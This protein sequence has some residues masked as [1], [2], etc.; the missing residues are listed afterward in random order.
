MGSA[1]PL[2]GAKAPSPT[3]AALGQV[4]H[5]IDDLPV[6]A[7]LEVEVGAEAEAGA[8]ADP[9]HLALAHLLADGDRYR[10][11]VGVAGGETAAVVDTGVVAVAGLRAGD[12]HGAGGSRVDGRPGRDADVDARVAGLP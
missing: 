8:V 12:R 5:G 11:L 9:D 1:A 3:H 2:R 4:A 7:H 10:L 6:H